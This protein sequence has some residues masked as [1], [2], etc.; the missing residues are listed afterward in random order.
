M[1]QLTLEQR[2][3]KRKENHT[4]R[5]LMALLASKYTNIKADPLNNS[6]SVLINA[7]WCMQIYTKEELLTLNV[8]ELLKQK[9]LGKVRISLLYKLI[10]KEEPFYVQEVKVLKKEK[11][12]VLKDKYK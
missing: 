12:T 2:N 3:I 11:R 7:L 4:D 8:K 5:P 1:T 10:G 6:I 9:G